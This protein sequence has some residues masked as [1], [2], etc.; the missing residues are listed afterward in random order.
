[1][2]TFKLGMCQIKVSNSKERNI[3]NA[4][5]HLKQC[6]N[7][8][9]NIAVLPEMFNCPYD[10]TKFGE[11]AES[12]TT[13]ET[14]KCMAETAKQL[15]M[16]IVAGSIPEIE[17]SKIYNTC[18]VFDRL[19]NIIGKHRKIHLFDINIPG[20]MVFN[21][22]S[23]LTAGDSVTV[24]DTDYAKLGIGICF[25]MRF[26]E[27]YSKMCR[28]GAEC[29]ITPGAFNMFTGP[30]HWELLVRA[31]AL[32]NLL[33]HAAVSP[34]RNNSSSYIAY[35]NSMIVNPWGTILTKAEEQEQIIYADI[36]LTEIKKCRSKIPIINRVLID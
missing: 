5:W 36:D 29:I 3:D 28:M 32:D 34:A 11:F 23:I 26:P 8:G 31:R 9:V 2:E 1:M 30:A 19:G 33:Y 25:D 16:F 35:G 12:I 14:V 6:R 17:N 7:N 27:L 15:D 18:L 24:V 13:G 21:E 20:K 4:V 10:I 22:S